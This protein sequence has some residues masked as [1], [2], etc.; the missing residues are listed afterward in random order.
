MN[1]GTKFLSDNRI[2]FNFWAPDSKT[3]DLCV[4]NPNV[5]LS[6]ELPMKKTHDGWFQL[7]TDHVKA[8]AKY[9]FRLA[10]GMLVPDPAS[11]FQEQDVHGPS[12]VINPY[13]FH[14][15]ND[16]QWRGLPWSETVIYEL[17]TGTIFKR[18]HF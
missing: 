11:R 10:N 18:R 16:L 5:H 7:I 9:Q 2:E 12:I 6:F 17:H 4:K 13:E 1:F 14:W 8:A 3:V 15:G